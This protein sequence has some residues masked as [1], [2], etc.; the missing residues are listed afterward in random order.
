MLQ[1]VTYNLKR[2]SKAI[3]KVFIYNINTSLNSVDD[4][5]KYFEVDVAMLAD[6]KNT[7]TSDLLRY[8]NDKPDVVEIE[9]I[10]KVY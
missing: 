2:K 10:G 3:L 1:Q 4:T 8:Y 6:K 7:T 5:R 9:L